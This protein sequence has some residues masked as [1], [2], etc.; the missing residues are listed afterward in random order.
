MVVTVIMCQPLRKSV[1][2]VLLRTSLE[3]TT[4]S[5]SQHTAGLRQPRETS[6]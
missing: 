1:R 6:H 2:G 4:P 5:A 3:P